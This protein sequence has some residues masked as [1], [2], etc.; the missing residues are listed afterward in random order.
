MSL[1]AEAP[2]GATLHGC[3]GRTLGIGKVI[4]RVDGKKGKA[5]SCLVRRRLQTCVQSYFSPGLE[6]TKVAGHCPFLPCS[7]DAKHSQL[8]VTPALHR[9]VEKAH[10]PF[11]WQR[12]S[13][14]PDPEGSSGISALPFT[15]F[16]P[17]KYD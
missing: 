5:G 10:V 2:S 14:L 17:L 9:R 8:Q 13:W 3:E 15:W 4:A 16:L 7:H 6:G 1:L 11:V 12:G